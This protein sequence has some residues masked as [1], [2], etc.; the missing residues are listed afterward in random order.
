MVEIPFFDRSLET[1]PRERLR[2]LQ[3]ERFRARAREVFPANRFVT[4]RWKAAGIRSADDLHSWDDFFRLPFTTKAEL[5]L[6][7]A[8]HPPFGTN[9]TYALPRYVRVHQTSGTTGAP[10]RWVETPESWGW[11]GRC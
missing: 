4:E 11:W 10:I 9:L 2:T 8:A 1:L 5:V 6:D 3:W 7:Q